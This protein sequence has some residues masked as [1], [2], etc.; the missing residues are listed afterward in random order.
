MKTKILS[1]LALTVSCS[2]YAFDLEDYATTMRATRDA[3]Q[4]AQLDI[5][6]L[7]L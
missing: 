4:K 6:H 7:N 5:F 1:I 2:S 3:M